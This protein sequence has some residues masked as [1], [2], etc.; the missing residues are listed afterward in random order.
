[1]FSV[2]KRLVLIPEMRQLASVLTS[3]FLVVMVRDAK[4]S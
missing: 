1:M 4:E 2:K 3:L